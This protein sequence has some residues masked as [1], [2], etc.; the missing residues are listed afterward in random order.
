MPIRPAAVEDAPQITA[1]LRQL[2]YPDAQE[3]VAHR[4]DVLGRQDDTIVLAAENDGHQLTG[5]IQIIIANRLA[6]GQYGEI[7]SLVVAA[8][9]RGDGIGRQLVE[10]AADWLTEKGIARLSVRCNAIRKEAHRFYA[11][12][13]F[14]VIKSQKIFDRDLPMD[15]TC[16]HDE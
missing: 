6:E 3:A 7:A 12:L 2:G 16:H 14:R 10:S 11:H 5:C 1:L 15:W 9:S 4:L 13:G 8:D